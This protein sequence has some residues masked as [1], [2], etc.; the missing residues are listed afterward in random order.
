[1]GISASFLGSI[2]FSEYFSKN[3]SIRCDSEKITKILGFKVSNDKYFEYL[4]KLGFDADD[5]YVSVPP[6][7]HDITSVNDVAEEIARAIGYNNISSR[8]F[9]KV[10]LAFKCFRLVSV[11]SGASKI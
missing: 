9:S 2:F 4:C 10:A 8:S 1:M 7:R 11:S 3:K 5:S 6:Y